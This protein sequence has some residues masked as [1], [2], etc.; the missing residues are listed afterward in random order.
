MTHTSTLRSTVVLAVLFAAVSLSACN[1]RDDSQTA[2]QKVDS[3]IAKADEK[4]DAAKDAM[5]RDATAAQAAASQAM[6]EARQ[7]T[8]DAARATGELLSDSAITTRIKASLVA[9]AELKLRDISVETQAGRAA[10]RGTAPNAGA[11]DRA[12]Q[13]A[14]AVQGVVAVDN[15]LTVVQ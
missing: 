10:L 11:R 2:G 4:V 1:R 5:A 14:S 9:D 3:A 15:Q 13:L 8:G 7:A 6:G 12:S